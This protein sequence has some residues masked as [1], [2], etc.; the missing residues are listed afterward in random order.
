MSMAVRLR[1]L[2]RML[3]GGAVL[4]YPTEGVWGL[5]C[6]PWNAD[7]VMR[8][9]ALKRRPM[10]RGLILVGASLEQLAP[11]VADLPEEWQQR[12]QDERGPPTSWLVPHGGAVPPWICGDSR[13]V[14][15]RICRQPQAAALCRAFGG[16]IV[17]T[18]AN[19]SGRPAALSALRVRAY[20]GRN[21]DQLLPGALPDCGRPSRICRIED[22]RRLR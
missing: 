18:S 7:A 6:D 1:L 3:D 12:I 11:L 22:G 5:G 2:A 19:P 10:H 8:I 21:I 4:A 9:L 20:F 16:A 15:L 14:A 13:H 17:S